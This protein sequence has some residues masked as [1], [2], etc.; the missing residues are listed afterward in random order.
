MLSA[1]DERS[2][3]YVSEKKGQENDQQIA[4]SSQDGNGIVQQEVDPI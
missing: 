4:F 3:A 2:F 1:D